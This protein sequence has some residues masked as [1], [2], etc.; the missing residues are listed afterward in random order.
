MNKH[1]IYLILEYDNTF[2][3]KYRKCI[4]ELE[5]FIKLFNQI[6]I[7]YNNSIDK[8]REYFRNFSPR[9]YKFF[10]NRIK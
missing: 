9:F 10:N 3:I 8:D 1:L 5:S 6:S 4:D 7:T 2:N